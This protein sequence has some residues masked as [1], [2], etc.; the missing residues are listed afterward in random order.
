MK[1]S[2]L[3]F[4]EAAS[5]IVIAIFAFYTYRGYRRGFIKQA[6]FYISTVIALFLAPIGMPI[7]IGLLNSIDLTAS[8]E[9][10]LN[11]YLEAYAFSH[12]SALANLTQPYSGNASIIVHDAITQKVLA[13]NASII[14][15]NIVRTMAYIFGYACIRVVLHFVLDVGKI[16]A[17]LPIIGDFDKIIGGIAAAVMTLFAMWMI[18]AVVS[19]LSFLP[20]VGTLNSLLSSIP[21]LQQIYAINPFQIMIKAV[22]MI[23]K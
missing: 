17:A 9:R 15:N 21:I 11:T 6:T 23:K 7:F 8:I 22:E 2:D 20:L 3:S 14:A 10:G 19:L 18:L 13:Q 5:L 16:I 4:N 12:S 1:L